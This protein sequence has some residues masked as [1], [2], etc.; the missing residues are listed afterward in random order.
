[1]KKIVQIYLT[2]TLWVYFTL[3][4]GWLLLYSLT[5]DSL[6]AIS[7]VNMLAVYLFLPLPIIFVFA[8]FIRRVEIWV[9]A[10]LGVAAFLWLWGALFLPQPQR[11]NDNV[12]TVMT[13][14]VLGNHGFVA[15][16]IDVIRT[17][18]ADVVLLQ[19]MNPALSAALQTELAGVYPFQILDPVPGVRGMGVLS[20]YPIESRE[21]E[22]PLEWVGRPQILSLHWKD[23]QVTLVNFHMH[24]S[25]LGTA[26]R[27]SRDNHYRQAQAQAL[28]TL[29]EEGSP[30]ILGGD[31]NTTPLND[32]YKTLT[33]VYTDAW[34]IA[35]FGLGHTFPG[36]DI[37]GSSR[38]RIAGW[39]VPPWLTRIDYIFHSSH[40]QTIA[41]YNAVFDGVSDHRGVV[42]K[43]ILKT[44]FG[45]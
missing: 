40:W 36:S 27:I 31:A 20:K 29:A 5:G 4:F 35:G 23:T 18:N 1:V 16:Q 15:P 42:A 34:R 45:D 21:M 19:E 22:L 7:I 38:P 10:L 9:A 17:E 43:M 24:P 3:L 37:P 44:R 6:G 41:A 28:A 8:F 30:I 32:A 11:A 39:S 14:N 2:A 13:Y 12:L 26:H 33:R 25:T